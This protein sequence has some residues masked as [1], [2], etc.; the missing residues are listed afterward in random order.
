M[1][2]HRVSIHG[3]WPGRDH[4]ADEWLYPYGQQR[5]I[6]LDGGLGT[7][8][9]LTAANGQGGNN[10]YNSGPL[11]DVTTTTVTGLPTDGSQ[12]YV[13]LFSY[14]NGQWVYNE[15]QYTAYS[16]AAGILA[17]N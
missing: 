16:Q 15:Y 13:T 8:F 11:G 2:L 17:V 12:V 3:G 5:A 10:Y 4:I 14:V 1:V 7:Q 9:W 6:H